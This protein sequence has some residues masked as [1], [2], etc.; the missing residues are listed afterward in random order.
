MKGYIE[1]KITERDSMRPIKPSFE[2]SIQY[3]VFCGKEGRLETK[4]RTFEGA[5]MAKAHYKRDAFI[6]GL[7]NQGKLN[8]VIAYE[9]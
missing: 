3:S 1:E 4:Q 9:H 6:L 5:T 8:E 2:C 7:D